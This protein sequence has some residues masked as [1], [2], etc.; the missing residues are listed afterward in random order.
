MQFT[1]KEIYGK[2]KSLD[3]IFSSDNSV[4]QVLGH[5]HAMLEEK[6][7]GGQIVSIY[8]DAWVAQWLSIC[9]L[10]A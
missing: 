6:Q 10:R 7:C 9:L 1:K 8:W 5:F 2:Y 4:E 3:W